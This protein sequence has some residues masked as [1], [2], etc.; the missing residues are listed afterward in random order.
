MQE[1]WVQALSQAVFF[2]KA[3]G[4]G[5]INGLKELVIIGVVKQG[6]HKS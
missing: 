3:A 6:R 5:M 4:I 2:Q 1:T